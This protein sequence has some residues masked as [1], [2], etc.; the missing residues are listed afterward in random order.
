M[1]EEEVSG[2]LRQKRKRINGD[3]PVEYRTEHSSV[4]CSLSTILRVKPLQSILIELVHI[5]SKSRVLISLVWKYHILY[6]LQHN[7][8]LPKI[9][10]TYLC[11]IATLLKGG[12]CKQKVDT[13]LQNCVDRVKQYFPSL[14]TTLPATAVTQC[15]MYC[16][17]AMLTNWQTFN[18]HHATASL[19]CWLTNQLRTL[20]E[21]P[22]QVRQWKKYVI[23]V[24]EPCL[25][26]QATEP[27]RVTFPPELA[28]LRERY[29]RHQASIAN[30]FQGDVVQDHTQLMR[31]FWVMRCETDAL[32]LSSDQKKVVS[33]LP[34]N[35]F[36]ACHVKIDQVV[37]TSLC[38]HINKKRPV[39]ERWS[40]DLDIQALWKETFHLSEIQAMRRTFTFAWSLT[41]N[42]V[43]AS[44]LY[45]RHTP[46]SYGKRRSVDRVQA[47]EY[48]QT[49]LSFLVSSERTH[50]LVAIDPGKCTL[51]ST[52][53]LS[54]GQTQ[55][56][57]QRRY[58]QE[59]GLAAYTS[60]RR[61]REELGG[62][63]AFHEALSAL[64][65]AKTSGQ[66]QTLD[67][68]IQTL[69]RFWVARWKLVLQRR[70]LKQEWRK[71]QQR[72]GF[73]DRV[74]DEVAGKVSVPTE[75][76]PILLFGKGGQHFGFSKT[77]GGGV[78]GPVV[79]LR[80]RLAK[81]VMVVMCS[82]FRTSKCCMACGGS[83][84]HPD[85]APRGVSFCLNACTGKAFRM[86]GRDQAAALCIGA[87]FLAQGYGKELGV[88]HSQVKW[89]Q[90]HRA[91]RPEL[92]EALMM[93]RGSLAASVA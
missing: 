90:R 22:T 29:L 17:R 69:A 16:V 61:R 78:C 43:S 39:A 18:T 62:G 2:R 86:V 51:L 92:Q 66:Y 55:E 81:R 75:Q 57:T 48:E 6:L 73:M 9:N 7:L 15:L 13:I 49:A 44:I 40:S 33:I 60:L 30:M 25:D 19:S 8:P 65:G 52:Y 56:V 47:G 85:F 72:Q 91:P 34:E 20:T 24:A 67:D 38:S 37:L 31:H 82:E 36:R 80:K 11:R 53:R 74:V 71:E 63:Q 32:P 21:N 54:D 5:V 46:K 35:H 4:R 76:R 12:R 93:Y 59:S 84:G 10:Q 88:F 83:M 77:R 64:P 58:R 1:E 27:C 26:V 70:F 87:R 3:R 41:T 79:E 14:E 28:L 68:Y 23:Q 50:P 42:G 45:E 89:D